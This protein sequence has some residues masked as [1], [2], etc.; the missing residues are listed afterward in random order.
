MWLIVQSEFSEKNNFDILANKI[1]I[2]NKKRD[3]FEIKYTFAFNS[4][5][6]CE[7]VVCLLASAS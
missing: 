1:D 3:Y 2:K 5:K 7:C 6:R 4:I